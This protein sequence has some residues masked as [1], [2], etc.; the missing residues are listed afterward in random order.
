LTHASAA[1]EDP[2]KDYVRIALVHDLATT[3]EALKRIASV[4]E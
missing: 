2:G 3:E 4:L 1:A